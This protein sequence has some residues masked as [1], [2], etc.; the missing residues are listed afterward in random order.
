VIAGNAMGFDL[1]R[2]ASGLGYSFANPRLL[3]QALTHASAHP[4]KAG[5]DYERLEF[6]GDRVLAL[7]IAE[8]MLERHAEEAEGVIARR[9]TELVRREALASVASD[10]RLG[11]FLRLSQG[12]AHSGARANKGLLADVMEA[13]IAAV[14]LDGGLDAARQTVRRLWAGLVEGQ[15]DAPN[16]P[17]TTLQEWAQARHLPLPA[18]EVVGRTGPDHAPSFVVEVRV[19]GCEPVRAEGPSKRVAERLAASRMLEDLA[20]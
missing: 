3:K 16:D 9:F 19:E 14:Y 1:D 7:I 13:V 15:V 5:N 2:L 4:G 11:G 20:P 10:L 8:W 17:K 18:Y 6:L 12:E